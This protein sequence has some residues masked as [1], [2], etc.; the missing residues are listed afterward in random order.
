M[1]TIRGEVAVGDAVRVTF[2]EKKMTGLVS[3]VVSKTSVNIYIIDPG[4]SQTDLGG[5]KIKLLRLVPHFSVLKERKKE[6][7]FWEEIDAVQ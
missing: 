3:A 4:F 7:P 2:E 5:R 1:P 6:I